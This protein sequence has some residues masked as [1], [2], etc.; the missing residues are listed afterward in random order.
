ME[1]LYRQTHREL[2]PPRPV[3]VKVSRVLTPR[4]G[5]YSGVPLRVRAYGIQLSHIAGG[6]LLGWYQLDNGRPWW[7]LVRF[8]VRSANDRLR[9]DLVQLVPEIA[10][11]PR[12][13]AAAAPPQ[14]E[15]PTRYLPR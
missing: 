5:G 13:P 10:L 1:D 2:D 9:L 12:D 3:W 4:S 15:H 7:G 11:S 6:D 8:T 14:T